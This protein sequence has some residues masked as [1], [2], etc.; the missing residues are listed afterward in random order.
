MSGW[1]LVAGLDE[2]ADGGGRG[3]KDRDA[4]FLDDF[5]EAAEVGEIGGALVHH[6]GG[7][8]GK[9]AV[10]DVGMAGDPADIGGAPVDILIAHIE[11]VLRGRVGAGEVAAGAVEDAFGFA[12]RAGGVEHEERMLGVESLGCVF[13]G[14]FRS[15]L[16]PP[17]IALGLHGDR[18]AAA[19]DHDDAFDALVFFECFVDGG[20]ERDD[21][22]AAPSAIGGDDHAGAGVFESIDDGLGG[23]T[24]KDDRV[25]RADAGAGKHRD[26]RFGDHRQINEHAIAGLHTVLFEHIGKAA[27]IAMELRVGDDAF[28]AGFAFPNDGGFVGARA[29]R[30]TVD[31]IF[32]YIQFATDEPL[33]ER[34]LPVEDLVPLFAPVEF[35]G[36]ARPELVRLFNRFLVEFFVSRHRWDAGFGGKFL[37]GKV[38]WLLGFGLVGFFRTHGVRDYGRTSDRVPR[39]LECDCPFGKLSRAPAAAFFWRA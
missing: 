22:A 9:R 1:E 3:V 21:L 36:F 34:C 18:V 6:L 24:A 35:L 39:R 32:T 10:D 33:R 26:D 37:T 17:G 15:F 30:M 2:G 25:H 13:G 7:A 5:P 38:D 8:I 4:V 29:F 11:D 28:V 23:E 27:D 31:A 19:V 16:V 20:F 12:G 14:N